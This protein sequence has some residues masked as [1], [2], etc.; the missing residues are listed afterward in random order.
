M[1]IENCNN[2]I[3]GLCATI[4]NPLK[5]GLIKIY[6]HC[7]RTKNGKLLY[8]NFCMGETQII[9]HQNN[10]KKTP[11]ESRLFLFVHF[12]LCNKMSNLGKKYMEW[13]K[14]LRQI[15]IK[16]SWLFLTITFVCPYYLN[17]YIHHGPFLAISYIC[18]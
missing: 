13:N 10:S 16:V 3:S 7:R 6:D 4:K 18:A 15:T 12:F 14:L 8:R 9:I 11:N 1:K 17:V 2:K 5:S